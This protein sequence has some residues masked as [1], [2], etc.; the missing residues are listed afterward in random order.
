MLCD[1][2]LPLSDFHVFHSETQTDVSK[3]TLNGR[4][5]PLTHISDGKEILRSILYKIRDESYSRLFQTVVCPNREIEFF[6]P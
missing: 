6:Y 4:N 2:T 1:S 3:C 5:A